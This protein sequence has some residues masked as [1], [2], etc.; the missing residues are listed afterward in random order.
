MKVEITLNRL[1]IF[2]YKLGRMKDVFKQIH[3]FKM[4]NDFSRIGG[5]ISVEMERPTPGRINMILQ[6]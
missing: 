6:H 1:T 3:G 5:S 2:A 4:I